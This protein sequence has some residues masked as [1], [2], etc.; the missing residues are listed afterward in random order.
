MCLRDVLLNE[1]LPRVE[2]PSRY[3]GTELNSVHKD[4]ASVDLRICLFFPDL[5]ELGLGNL[6]LH[7]LYAVLN[8]IEGVWAERGYTPAR[9]MEAAL[10]KRGL[11]LF[12]YESKEPLSRAD[13]IGFTL[14]SELT[15]VNAL[16]ALDLAGIPLRSANRNDSHPLIFA[17]GPCAYNPEPMAPFM[18][19]FVI[20]DGED[21]VVELV[22]T[23]RPLQ[24]A[25][26]LK[27][28]EALAALEGFYVPELYPVDRFPD[29]R[30]LPSVDAP[31]IRKRVV[32]DLD[33]A[34]FPARYIVPFTQLIHDAIN[35]EVLRGCTHG[36]RFCQAGMVTRPARERSIETVDRLLEA[37]LAHTGLE[38]VALVSLSTCDHSRARSLVRHCADRAHGSNASVSLPSLRLDS[39]SV[40]LADMIGEVRRSGLTFA[41]EAATPRLRSVINKAIGDAE[42]LEMS[43]EAFRRGWT[44]VKTYFMIGLPTEGDEDVQAIADLCIRTLE[45]GRRITSRAMVRTGVSTFVPKPFTPFQ[46]AAQIGPEETRRRQALLADAF[47]RYRAIK[48]G[49]HS[50]ETSFIEGLLTRADRRAADLLEAVWR[51]G[52]GFETWD[53]AIDMNAWNAA[54]AET[55]YD[56]AGQFRQ[57]ELD[58][59]LPWDHIDVLIP[60][61]WYQAEWRRAMDLIYMP[62]CRTGRCNRCG[63]QE[64]E[65][66]L[67]AEMLQRQAA[68]QREEAL[69]WEG[70]ISKRQISANV[71]A[72]SVQ[73]IRF[74]IGRVGEARLLGH[75]EMQ[76][77][78]VRAFRRVGAPL[79]YSKGFHA[80]PKLSF[81]AAAPVGEE[82]EGDYLDVVLTGRVDPE[83]LRNRLDRNLPRDFRVYEAVEVP[84]RAPSLMSAVTGF[85]YT[86]FTP[87]EPDV[88]AGR[89]QTLLE[90]KEL[91]IAR[92]AKAG[93]I[94][95]GAS[96]RRRVETITI[97][98]RPMIEEVRVTANGD[99]VPIDFTTRAVNHRFAK[100]REI[101]ELLGLNPENTRILKRATHLAADA[102]ENA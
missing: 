101:I 89:I 63:V 5:Y 78:W 59:R 66:A 73:R 34:R 84:L 40:E 52:G 88:L 91:L 93:S 64:R 11:P 48:F 96:R 33:A 54:I 82:S 47:K 60:K 23:L 53:E 87:G 57:R 38:A 20:G 26:R 74:R 30:V 18:D 21:A 69:A 36:C 72:E 81:A 7:I 62:D 41:P 95:K 77:A 94:G 24:A 31:K 9:D 56:A 67:C 55:G 100:P 92:R 80:H 51:H 27:K 25:P 97:D 46:W 83:D 98:I 15:Y 8:D 6:G 61:E 70:R 58:E 50:A 2:R 49:R 79:A 4:P 71:S 16:N 28:L 3:L 17:G 13:L 42:L 14:Q 76:A 90:R 19:F 35:L 43:A 1:I 44:H 39:F 86:L 99:T 22:E 102:L 85:S 29:G 32:R 45:G 37:T 65:R 75:L 10:R 12:L 68:G